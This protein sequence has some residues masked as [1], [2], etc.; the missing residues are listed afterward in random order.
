MVFSADVYR[1]EC[2]PIDNC[3]SGLSFNGEEEEKEKEE[4]KEGKV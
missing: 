2:L 4:E 1:S 3:C